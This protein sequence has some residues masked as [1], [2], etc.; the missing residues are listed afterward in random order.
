M[1]PAGASG[2]DGGGEWGVVCRDADE[3][4]PVRDRRAYVGA[5]SCANAI[6]V[7]PEDE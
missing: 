5:T 2:K 3:G 6:D 7:I 4:F 1:S